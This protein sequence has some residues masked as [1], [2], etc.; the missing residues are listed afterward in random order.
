MRKVI[1]AVMLFAAV[2]MANQMQRDMLLFARLSSRG[3]QEFKPTDIDGLVVWLD[4]ADSSTI[5]ADAARTTS[6]TNNGII[7]AWDDKSGNNRGFSKTVSD[8][9]IYNETANAIYFNT[10]AARMRGPSNNFLPQTG[11]KTIYAVILSETAA[12]SG[13]GVLSYALS[14]T[15]GAAGGITTEIALRTATRTWI[16]SSPVST[17]VT[18]IVSMTQASTG[19]LHAATKMFRNGKEVARTSGTDGARVDDEQD[20]WIGVA[21]S[22]T[23]YIGRMYEI[24]MYNTEHTESQRDQVHKYLADKW[25]I[26]LEE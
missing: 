18:A 21:F 14:T 20:M 11:A 23:G 3:A 10:A 19:N 5:W 1:I 24:L 9:P 12:S 17:N 2:C 6:A 13:N 22:T 25:S 8:R 26:T 15:T 7:E 4:G 16:S